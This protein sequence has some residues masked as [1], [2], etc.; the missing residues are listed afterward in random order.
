MKLTGAVP[1]FPEL[2]VT[3]TLLF[4]VPLKPGSGTNTTLPFTTAHEPTPGSSYCC[5][6]FEPSQ[7]AT[8]PVSNVAPLLG[9]APLSGSTEPKELPGVTEP[10]CGGTTTAEEPPDDEGEADGAAVGADVGDDVGFP[11]GE[12][13]GDA[14][15]ELEGEGLGEAVAELEGDALGVA[16]G[17]ALGVALACHCAY[18]VLSP[19]I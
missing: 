9:V 3:R 16:D 6:Q 10:S 5:T 11:E 1:D 4:A 15:A 2:S 7:I 19:V 17:E 13:L 18:T 8:E 14:L 12:P